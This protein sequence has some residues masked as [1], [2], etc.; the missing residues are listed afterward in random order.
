[1]IT[2]ILDRIEY[3]INVRKCYFKFIIFTITTKNSYL[4]YL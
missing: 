1:M 4:G 2:Y 3:L